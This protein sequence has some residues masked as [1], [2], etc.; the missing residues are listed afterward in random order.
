MCSLSPPHFGCLQGVG[1]TSCLRWNSLSC[2]YANA[3]LT[4]VH[5]RPERLLPDGTL[6]SHS[7]VYSFRVACPARQ[8]R[9]PLRMCAVTRARIS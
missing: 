4:P 3:Y 5:Y 8:M 9:H 1:L 6:C 2:P 7:P